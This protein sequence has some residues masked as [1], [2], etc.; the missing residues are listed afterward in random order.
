MTAQLGDRDLPLGPPRRRAL[1]GLLLIQ[2]GRPV[3]TGQLVEELWGERPP[4]HAKASLQSYVSHLRTALTPKAAPGGSE[5]GGSENGGAEKLV[6]HVA[7]GYVLD[8]D[9]SQVDAYRFEQLV[10]RGHRLQ[11]EREFPAARA[12]LTEALGL[13]RGL[14]YA[15]LTSYGALATE[16][17]R[18]EQ[19]RLSAVEARAD[20]CLALRQP[21]A[22]VAE[23]EREAGRYPLRERLVGQLMTALY[24]LGRQ[25]DALFVYERTRTS[26]LEELGIGAGEELQALHGAIMRQE[27]DS[28]N[29]APGEAERARAHERAP[30]PAA[31]AR[32]PETETP[33]TEAPKTGTAKTATAT[34]ETPKTATPNTATPNTEAPHV[35]NP[36]AEAPN[37]E[38]PKPRGF[39]GREAE[40]LE[41]RSLAADAVGGDGRVAAVLGEAGIGKTRLL[42]EL[43]GPLK[44]QEPD[45]VWGRCFAGQGVPP[46]WPWAQVLRQLSAQHPAAFGAAATRFGVALAP[47]MPELLPSAE[48]QSPQD[49]GA[50]ERFRTYDAVCEVLLALADQRPLLLLLEDLHWA[51]A[52]SLD[53]LRLLTTRQHGRP[54]GVVMTARETDIGTNPMLAQKLG[55]V[56]RDPR[57]EPLRLSGLSEAEVGTLVRGKAGSEVGTAVTRAL[58][59]RSKGNPYFVSQLLSLLGGT[60]GLHDPHAARL[61][62]A[63]V[64]SGV[65][66]VLR[67]RFATLPAEALLAL[68]TCAVLGTE[69]DLRLLNEIA[70]EELSTRAAIE[71][72]VRAQLLQAD[73]HQPDLLHFTHALVQETLYE[74]LAQDQ[75]ARLHAQVARTLLDRSYVPEKDVEQLAHHAWEAGCELPAKTALPSLLRAAEQAEHRLAYEQA[76]T[77][78]R[79]ATCLLRELP[80]DSRATP[81]VDQR[82]QIQ[83]GQILATIRGYGDAEAE[84]AFNRSR[85]LNAVTGT[86]DRPSVLWALCAAHL[87]TGRYEES[88]AFSGRLREISTRDPDPIAVLGAAY[89]QGI[90]LHVRGQLP[91]ALVE[92]ERGVSAADRFCSGQGSTLAKAFQH[93][94]RV[95]CRSY[96]AFTHWLLGDQETAMERREELLALAGRDSRPSDRAF[97]LYVDAILAGLEGDV[98]RAQWAGALGVEVAAEAGLRYWRAMLDVCLG[99]A[100][101]YTG[102]G[103]AGIAR[104]RAA[105]AELRTTRTLFRLPLHL[106]FLA[107]AQQHAGQLADAQVTLRSLIAEVEQ[108]NEHVYLNPRLPAARLCAELLGPDAGLR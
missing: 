7:S 66:E 48:Q 96:N 23:L 87:V 25:A 21:E 52:P 65:R 103:T 67:Q 63:R 69:V 62:L 28:A 10:A 74:E 17:A 26:L 1:L 39:A 94:P 97:A 107:Q 40:L 42:L 27:L 79:R 14:P 51:D 90:V 55:E 59:E 20:T 80:A 56:L 64:P 71:S 77:W 34:T 33:K 70:G 68:R 32:T 53:L 12:L 108:R 86:P 60:E 82:L 16:G 83:L 11:R 93:D 22:V 44:N 102:D 19:V 6:R 76:E 24:R 78:L 101:A 89:G 47:L 38:A 61:L 72:A 8:L 43:A 104:I 58:H 37:T 13:W 95:S 5:N 73:A 9:E 31:V 45:V 92:L 75:R 106:G 18:L 49:A 100:S 54:L 46:Y 84:V 105:L 50:Q 85:E 36:S 88:L 41:L 35:A 30:E 4:Q 99:W 81:E 3:S 29:G 98:D 91:A 57:T 15:D 2:L